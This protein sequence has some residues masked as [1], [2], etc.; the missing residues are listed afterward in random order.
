MARSAQ[1][2]NDCLQ[3]EITNQVFLKKIAFLT[4]EHIIERDELKYELYKL[5]LI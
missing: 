1:A 5:S 3:L 4:E 2:M